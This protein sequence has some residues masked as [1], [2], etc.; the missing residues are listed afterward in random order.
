MS[1]G[2]NSDE[3]LGKKCLGRP[4]ECLWKEKNCQL[5]HGLFTL[6]CHGWAGMP[7]RVDERTGVHRGEL[8]LPDN[9]LQTRR[10]RAALEAFTML[11]FMRTTSS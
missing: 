5:G 4:G 8:S 1:T 7:R 2:R 6:R 9:H 3:S 11:V 10:T